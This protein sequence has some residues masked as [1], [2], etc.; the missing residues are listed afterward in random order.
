MRIA[1]AGLS[2]RVYGAALDTQL[3]LAAAPAP[4]IQHLLHLRLKKIGRQLHQVTT[5]VN[6]KFSKRAGPSNTRLGLMFADRLEE[7]SSLLPEIFETHFGTC[8]SGRKSTFQ[9]HT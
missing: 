3:K 6:L 5:A 4:C 7:F 2:P 1:A 9:V 8:H